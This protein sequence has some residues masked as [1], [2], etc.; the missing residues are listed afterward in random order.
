MPE[1]ARR[2]AHAAIRTDHCCPQSRVARL[3]HTLLVIDRAALPWR[4]RQ[5]GVG[6]DLSPV[7]E[8]TEQ[9]L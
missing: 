7:V 3:G 4:R 6:S 9:A 1:D 2:P 8:L 5:T